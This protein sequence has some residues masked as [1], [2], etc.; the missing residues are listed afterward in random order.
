MKREDKT[1]IKRPVFIIGTGRSGTTLLYN[2]FA[3]HPEFAWF[4]N[5]DARYPGN[6]LLPVLSR[7]HDIPLLNRLASKTSRYVPRP[8][9]AYSIYNRCT[10]FVFTSK[11]LLSA[12]DVTDDTRR[13]YQQRVETQMKL[14]G[15]PRFLQKHTGFARIRYLRAIF[16]DAL[17]INVYRDGRA[18][19]YSTSK[20]G[21]WS[22][23]LSSWWWG[24]MKPEY[25]SEYLDA[26]KDPLILA[27][28][29]W[30]TL[31]DLIEEECAEL[32]MQQL[33]RIRYD[34]MIGDMAGTMHKVIRFCGLSESS[35]FHQYV[36][37][38]KVSNMDRKWERGLSSEEKEQLQSCIGAHLT[39]YG[40]SV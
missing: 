19:A 6:P 39:K 34:E 2:A 22:G 16:P 29:V 17:F 5:I 3:F 26:G 13:R 38:I 9:E 21:F 27:G 32:S 10:D 33:L 12:A 25:E 14:Q 11:H 4:S 20:V 30:K 24:E 28:I 36:R 8:S 18:V 37:S 7:F 15:K 40:F 1:T 23:D 31:M 35:E